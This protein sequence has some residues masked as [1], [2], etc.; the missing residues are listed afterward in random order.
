MSDLELDVLIDR[1]ETQS[2]LT[3]GDLSSVALALSHLRPDI[4]TDPKATAR[5]LDQTDGV[6]HVADLAYPNW[7]VN[8]HGRANDKDG[9]WRCTLREG[10]TRDNDRVIGSGR[11]PV[12]SQAILAALLRLADATR[13]G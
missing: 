6:M 2:D 1:L 7:A 9:H 13:G 11:S 12:L 10:D 5:H 8:V 3:L 4:V